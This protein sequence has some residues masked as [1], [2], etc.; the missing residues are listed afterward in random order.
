V[1]SERF[2]RYSQSGVDNRNR[3]I[4]GSVTTHI[5]DSFLFI[6]HAKWMVYELSNTTAE[7]LR[8]ARSVST[9]GSSQSVSSTQ[10]EE[11]V[12]LKHHKTILTEQYHQLSV[13]YEQ[14]RQMVM[15]MK[16][17]MGGTCVPPFWLYGP[18]NDQPPPP[19]TL[20]LFY[21]NFFVQ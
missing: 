5:D 18:G 21:F 11:I 20:P 3:Q 4:H 19:P 12:A 10:S 13:D 1:T 7:N 6:A 17:Q 15:D 9:I 8:A 2:T 16:S 14:L